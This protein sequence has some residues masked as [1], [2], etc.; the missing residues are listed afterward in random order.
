M[1]PEHKRNIGDVEVLKRLR[2][3]SFLEGKGTV[4]EMEGVLKYVGEKLA[5]KYFVFEC[6]LRPY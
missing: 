2:R 1:L 5:G 4:K 3:N 6:I